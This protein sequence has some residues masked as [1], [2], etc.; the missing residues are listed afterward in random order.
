MNFLEK[1]EKEISEDKPHYKKI[2]LEI[3]TFGWD[4]VLKNT[5]LE[6]DF[7]EEF[8]ENFYDW[9]KILKFQDYS[10]EFE[11]KFLYKFK[12]EKTIIAADSTKETILD[13]LERI[14]ISYDLARALENK[15]GEYI[16]S[17]LI[18]TGPKGREIFEKSK[19][20]TN[21]TRKNDTRRIYL[22]FDESF[23][24]NSMVFRADTTKKTF[25]EVFF[26]S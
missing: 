23:K 11:N 19:D 7:L 17:K 6:E 18:F 25:Q 20:I 1:I 16:G 8:I 24:K 3:K 13:W 2:Y 14:P 26:I 21:Y 4:W 5:K 9:S 10:P 15:S 22:E 12:K